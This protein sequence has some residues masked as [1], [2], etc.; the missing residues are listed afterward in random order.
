MG[1]F[2]KHSEMECETG[3]GLPFGAARDAT[4]GGGRAIR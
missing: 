1:W 3:L 2:E 4:F